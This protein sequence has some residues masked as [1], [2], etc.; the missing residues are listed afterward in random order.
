MAGAFHC[1]DIHSDDR[2]KTAFAT[3]FRTFQQKRLGF[4]V[5]NG[6]ATYYQLVDRVLQNIPLLVALSFVDNGIVHSCGLDQHL[7]NLDKTL[8]AYSDAGLK[9]GPR[10]CT[11]SPQITYLGH[12]VDQHSIKPVASYMEAV[13]D[14]P[15][16]KYKT[17]ARAFLGI[18]GYY[19]QHIRDY[20]KIAQ[21]WTDV[22]R[23]TAEPGSEKQKLTVTEAM[24]RAFNQLKRSLTTA[25]ILG[26]LYFKGP[27][28]GQFILDTDFCQTQTAGILSQMQDGREHH[29][30]HHRV[31]IQE[32]EQKPE[33]LP[34]LQKRNCMQ[35]LHGWKNTGTICST[36]QSSSGEQ[37]MQPLSGSRPWNP[38]GPHPQ[39]QREPVQN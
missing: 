22:I 3:P 8:Q 32:V 11:F 1:I 18:T 33:K 5:T 9:L 35:V 38:R 28:A 36:G 29:H 12:I 31:P 39:Y 14:W 20:T 27:M 15:L 21:P 6:P 19:R 25:P 13:R 2:E 30:R 17:E 4:G 26:F 37:I 7:K 24:T 10:K 34:H 23:K 16:P